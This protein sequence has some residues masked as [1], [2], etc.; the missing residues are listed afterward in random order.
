TGPGGREMGA[1]GADDRPEPIGAG[2]ATARTTPTT[3]WP[4]FSV[5]DDGVASST[6]RS[7]VGPGPRGAA[8]GRSASYLDDQI[9]A[10]EGS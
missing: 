10:F 6:D 7:S 2:T 9:R 4:G 3:C 1:S 5:A 8:R